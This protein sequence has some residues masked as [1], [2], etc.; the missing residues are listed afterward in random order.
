MHYITIE[1]TAFLKII[2]RLDRIESEVRSLRNDRITNRWLNSKEVLTIL[3]VSPKTLQNYRDRR[4]IPFSQV[5]NK[6]FYP[7]NGIEEFLNRN[8]IEPTYALPV[9]EP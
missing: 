9:D 2:E 3:K 6:I 8:L 4:L 5:G 1:E 7:L